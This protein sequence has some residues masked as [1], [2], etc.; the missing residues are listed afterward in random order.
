MLTSLLLLPLGLAPHFPGGLADIAEPRLIEHLGGLPA[1]TP[2]SVIVVMEDRMDLQALIDETSKL[3]KEA[4][5]EL[6]M[7]RMQGHAN[8]S[9]VGL[10]ALLDELE[11]EGRVSYRA[12][13]W[14]VNAHR[15]TVEAGSLSRLASVPG[16]A[17]VRWDP[18]M[19][20]E[21]LADV[22]PVALA[23]PLP[24]PAPPLAATPAALP[25]A[26]SFESGSFD[27]AWDQVSLAGGAQAVVTSGFGPVPDG[28]FH[29]LLDGTSGVNDG[30]NLTMHLDLSGGT[31]A[32]MT[33]D[34]ATLGDASSANDGLFI[35]PLG[36]P[37]KLVS[38]D[39]SSAY[40]TYT[41]DLALEAV[42][43]GVPLSS[44][45]LVHW[46]WN[47]DDVAP[48]EGFLLDDVDVQIAPLPT[49]PP[50]SNIAGLQAPEL[51]NLGIEGQGALILNIDSGA[52]NT[53]PALKNAIWS[54]PGEI[55]GNGIDDDSNGKIDDTWGWDFFSNDNSPLDNGHGNNTSGI[56][57]GDGTGNGGK[58]TG[59]APGASM[60]VA[61]I[62]GEG[63]ALEAYQ[64]AIA[65]GAD[66]ITSSYSFKYP[67]NPDYHTL[68]Q[69]SEAELAAGV[70]HANSIGNQGDFLSSYPLPYNISSPGN[71]PGP[72]RHPQQ[73]QS[74]GRSSVLGCAG[75]TEP[76]DA[77]YTAS[78]QGPSA[79]EDILPMKPS[80]PHPQNPGYWDYPY[81]SG[82]MPGLLKP[83]MCTYTNVKTTSGSSSYMSSFGGT[84]AATPH[85]GGA[86]CLMVSTNGHV[87]PRQISQALQETAL[88]LGPAGKDL[89]FGAGKAQVFDA[90]LKILGCVTAMPN[91]PVVTDTVDLDISGPAGS[92]W[93]LAIGFAPGTTV[94]GLGF[95]V[96]IA[97]AT[98]YASG[99]HSGVP[100]TIS[101]PLGGNPALAGIDAYLQ[102]VTEDSAG[103]SGQWLTSVVERVS[104]Q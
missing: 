14:N 50:E 81:A 7:Q 91:E 5:R 63:D 68:R 57:V 90:A 30:I 39:S 40:T 43:A 67:S 9:Q 17:Y 3:R 29:A 41:V 95:D 102:L 84:S 79:W 64:Y 87:P 20:Q 34:L 45:F 99:V 58:R 92:A 23:G 54:N 89:R 16:V 6:A 26:T 37:V 65:I 96:D 24:Q 83:D 103:P 13:L 76:G 2:V 70:I 101:V 12:M 88:D 36:N 49:I 11:A 8:A 27:A 53:H 59:M 1:V 93:F 56:V 44:D 42:T 80:F 15:V 69:A 18:I 25:Y 82:S 71:N 51:W 73:V 66:C 21:Q 85:L 35:G 55:P 97:G 60:A 94:T 100:S 19:G 77:L 78:G 33:F 75:V 74:G 98:L 10:L 52:N 28:S 72:W 4:R 48:N 22:G 32:V 86:L 47:D 61:R 38:F 31:G 62:S 46:R 104:I